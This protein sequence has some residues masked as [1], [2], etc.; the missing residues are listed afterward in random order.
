M[1]LYSYYVMNSDNSKAIDSFCF[2][3]WF[4]VRW[5]EFSINKHNSFTLWKIVTIHCSKYQNLRCLRPTYIV[6]LHLETFRQMH[7]IWVFTLH[8]NNRY[9][10][11]NR[12]LF[13][14]PITRWTKYCYLKNM[15]KVN[16]FKETQWQSYTMG[17][18]WGNFLAGKKLLSGRISLWEYWWHQSCILL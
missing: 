15:F 3:F 9:L 2:G 16:Y 7:I 17:K 4:F 11:H 13:F 8:S 1:Y 10:P 5:I 18:T 6:S 14:L 12:L